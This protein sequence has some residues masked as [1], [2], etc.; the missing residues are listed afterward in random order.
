MRFNFKNRASKNTGRKKTSKSYAPKTKVIPKK[1]TSRAKINNSTN[2]RGGGNKKLPPVTKET[3]KKESQQFCCAPCYD[4][5][6]GKVKPKSCFAAKEKYSSKNYTAP[7]DTILPTREG[8]G[9]YYYKDNR[10]NEKKCVF[11]STPVGCQRRS[12]SRPTLQ[13]KGSTDMLEG[14]TVVTKQSKPKDPKDTVNK[15]SEVIFNANKFTE[16]EIKSK[17]A[18]S[19]KSSFIPKQTEKVKKKQDKANTGGQSPVIFNRN[20]SDGKLPTAGKGY[21]G[22]IKSLEEKVDGNLP[23]LSGD[24]KGGSFVKASEA[25]YGGTK[26]GFEEKKNKNDKGR[27]KAIKDILAKKESLKKAAAKRAAENKDYKPLKEDPRRK[28]YKDYLDKKKKLSSDN[29][30]SR[31]PI[32]IG[33]PGGIGGGSPIRVQDIERKDIK[34]IDKLPKICVDKK[35][36]NYSEACESDDQCCVYEESLRDPIKCSDSKTSELR[37]KLDSIDAEIEVLNARKNEIINVL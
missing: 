13:K 36:L 2:N 26:S 25:A 4:L 32:G 7:N 14:I 16:S 3:I 22:V 20:V 15:K 9:V 35:A 6:K 30:V 11:N 33:G 37:I 19:K 8:K 31:L 10:G 23:G 12:K 18:T 28:T 17:T 24:K 29:E 34:P 1:T 5:V 27:N 21:S